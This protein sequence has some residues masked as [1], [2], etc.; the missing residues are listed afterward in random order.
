[1]GT[2]ALL[3]TDGNAAYREL[4]LWDVL[5]LPTYNDAVCLCECCRINQHARLQLLCTLP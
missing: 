5:H 4:D 2:I 3:V 1:M